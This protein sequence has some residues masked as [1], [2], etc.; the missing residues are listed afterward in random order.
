MKTRRTILALPVV[1]LVAASSLWAQQDSA[2]PLLTA[3]RAVAEEEALIEQIKQKPLNI[4]FGLS[5][6]QS[7]PQTTLAQAYDSLALPSV[8]YGFALHGGYYFDPVPVA[9]GAE[10]AVHFWGTRERVFNQQGA[11]DDRLQLST[12]NFTLPILTFVRFQPNVGSVVFPYAEGVLGTMLYSSSYSADQYRSDTV[13]ASYSKSEGGFNF[14]Y[15]VGAGVMIK[16]ADIITL[17]NTLNRYLIDIRFRYL[18]GSAVDVAVIEP[19]ED[20]SYRVRTVPVAAPEQIFF[21][22]GFVAQL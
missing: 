5:Y 17:P 1:F 21:Q 15:G 16:F 7:V 9:V 13:S 4:Q 20:Q 11:F 14:T 10:V 22:I 8:G 6:S 2:S 12:Q 3:T 18:W 19:T